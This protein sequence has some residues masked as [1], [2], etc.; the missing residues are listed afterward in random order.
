MIRF[1]EPGQ[2]IVEA[3]VNNN[4]LNLTFNGYMRKKEDIPNYL[5]HVEKAV[6]AL[7]SGYT[8]FVAIEKMSKAPSLATTGILRK[9]QSIVKEAGLSRAAVVLAKELVLQK[10]SLKV[11]TR[12]SG[13]ANVKIFDAKDEAEKWLAEAKE[14]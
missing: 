9:S 5:E 2:Y 7:K 14:E 4:R 11:V 12:L 8:S 6:K 3:D 13:L 1:E 10:M